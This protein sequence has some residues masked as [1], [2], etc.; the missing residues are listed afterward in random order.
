MKSDAIRIFV[1]GGTFDKN[2]NEL[3]GSLFFF[4]PPGMFEK[5]AALPE[6]LNYLEQ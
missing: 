6:D 3:D 5:P 2:Y 4:Y 1:T